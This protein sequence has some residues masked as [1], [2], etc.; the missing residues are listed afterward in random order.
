M[1]KR[2]TTETPPRLPKRDADSHKGT[3]GTVLAVAGSRDMAG[4]AILTAIA[5]LRSGAGLVQVACPLSAQAVIAAGFP[6]YTTIPLNEDGDGQIDE[7]VPTRLTERIAKADAVAIGPG[8]GQ[9]DS[10]RAFVRKLVEER[11]KP[12]VADADGLNALIGFEPRRNETPLVLTPHP[13]E[14][15]RLIF[16]TTD[17]VQKDREALAKAFAKRFGCILLLKGKG[18]IITDGLRLSVNP[19]GNPGMATGGSGDALTGVIAALLGQGMNAYEAARLG[20]WVHGLAGDDAAKRLG[21][22]SMTA[23][24]IVDSLP[25]AFMELER[26]EIA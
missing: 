21:M 25:A 16:S 22:V 9:G 24:D 19:T 12:M 10:L 11:T 1:G 3:F 5:A 8:L 6:C 2:M 4:A 17:A 26:M 20:A 15:A 23:K 7:P 18:T 14:F 13:G